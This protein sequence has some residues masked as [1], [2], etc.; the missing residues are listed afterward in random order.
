MEIRGKVG[1]SLEGDWKGMMRAWIY[2]RLI[3]GLTA[4]WYR[5][6]LS[7][8]PEEAAI[9]DVGIGTAGALVANADL[10]KAKELQITG[11]DIDADY[12]RRARERIAASSTEGRITALV[13]SVYDH[14]GGPYDVVYFSASFML[15]PEP[16]RA[17]RH[18][19]T[20]LRPGGRLFFTQTIQLRPSRV[21]EKLKPVLKRF[22][23]I[24]FGRVT[25]EESFRQEI[26]N[27]GLVLEDWQV[28][29][30][31]G[32]RAACLAVARPEA[33]EESQ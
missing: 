33:T 28:L 23:S 24:D 19:C 12:I 7:R 31:Q 8:V 4:E 1:G 6:V 26:Q 2:D 30:H 13:Q 10:V 18:C 21:M 11:I 32:P 5:A 17:L 3:L 22:T 27:A 16:E 29:K 14:Q 9:L 15:L 20:L 25:Y